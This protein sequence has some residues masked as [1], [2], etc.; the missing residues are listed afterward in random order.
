SKRDWSSDVC[1]SDLFIK[2]DGHPVKLRF[3]FHGRYPPF[4]ACPAVPPNRQSGHPCSAFPRFSPA[5]PVRRQSANPPD[6]PHS[7]ASG[8]LPQTDHPE[9]LPLSWVRTAPSSVQEDADN[10]TAP[11]GSAP[12]PD[13]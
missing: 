13:G 3:V 1:S 6:T 11:A 5:V 8:R 2:P 4:S 12:P 9:Y 7:P 10:R